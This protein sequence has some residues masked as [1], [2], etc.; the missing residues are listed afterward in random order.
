MILGTNH[1]SVKKA[2]AQISGKLYHGPIHDATT[3]YGVF[4]IWKREKATS[5]GGFSLYFPD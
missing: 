2:I 3:I 4:A 1:P 5:G